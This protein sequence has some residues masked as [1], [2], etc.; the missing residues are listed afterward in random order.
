MLRTSMEELLSSGLFQQLSGNISSYESGEAG[1]R[2]HAAQARWFVP[3]QALMPSNVR[4]IMAG[5]LSQNMIV[6]VSALAGLTLLLT[7]FSYRL[8]R[9]SGVPE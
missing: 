1:I 2:S 4:L 8:I 9:R 7:A 5:W 6:Y 3:T